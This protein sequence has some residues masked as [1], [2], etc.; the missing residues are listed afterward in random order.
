MFNKYNNRKEK[1]MAK[2]K[3][4]T[5]IEVE[6]QQLLKA[7]NHIEKNNLVYAINDELNSMDSKSANSFII[8]MLNEAIELLPKY[9]LKTW[10]K[11]LKGEE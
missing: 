9:Q 5:M 2:L 1:N 6:N 3:E 7:H 8:S 10:L 4:A 11:E